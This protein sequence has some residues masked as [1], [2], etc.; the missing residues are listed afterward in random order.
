MQQLA[1]ALEAQPWLE[2]ANKREEGTT[3]T[4]NPVPLFIHE[5]LS[6]Q[7]ILETAKRNDIQREL[8][9]DP[10]QKYREAVQFYEHEVPW[11]NRLI[12][13]DSLQ[14]MDSLAHRE[15]LAEQVQ[16][17]YIDPPYG[18]NFRSKFQSEV[19]R[20][21][22]S[23]SDRDLTREVEQI[24]AYRDTWKLGV[25]SYLSYLRQRFVLA[26]E[27][28]KDSG[29]V[30]VQISDENVHRVRCLLDEVFGP[31]N[32]MAVIAFRTRTTSKSKYL[33]VVNDF[34]IWYAKDREQ[35]KFR[36]LFINKEMGQD[37]QRQSYLL[38]K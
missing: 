8:F 6:A 18:I 21:S 33:T 27:L 12:L 5:R 37:F 15:G 25:H 13:G 34:I 26:R 20:T 30:F 7:A 16:M 22:V 9:A 17:I 38:E 4:V 14:V 19:F 3:F 2:W 35:L 11:A 29:S 32:F 36:R 31:E 1:D 28:L 23:D 24:K 10:Q